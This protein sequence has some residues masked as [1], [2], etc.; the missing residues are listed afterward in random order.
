MRRERTVG[1]GAARRNATVRARAD[2]GADAA[3]AALLDCAGGVL[4]QYLELAEQYGTHFLGDYSDT[5]RGRSSL[6]GVCVV[7]LMDF[8]GDG[9]EDLFVVYSNGETERTT[10]DGYNF[11]VYNFP[12]ERTYEIEVW[13]HEDRALKRLLHESGVSFSPKYQGEWRSGYMRSLY[14]LYVTV[15][16]DSDGLPVIQL[17]TESEA[18]REYTNI[19][20]S[21]GEVVRD[22]LQLNRK[23]QQL[24]LNGA[25]IDEAEWSARVAGYD[26]ILLSALLADSSNASA[27]V[28]DWYGIDYCDTQRQTN[29]VTAYLSRKDRPSMER[30][31]AAE[32]DYM[33]L[34]M[35]ELERMNRTEGYAD[36]HLYAL[37][38]M[39][40]DGVPEMILY[41]GSSGAGTHHHFYMVID[42]ELVDCGYDRRT[43]MFVD[44]NGGVVAYYAR[45]GGYFIQKITLVG[46][47]IVFTDIA[48]GFVTVDSQDYPSLEELG[49][50]GY[51]YLVYCPPALMFGFY[52]DGIPKVA[53]DAFE[54]LLP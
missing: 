5:Y 41:E 15:F 24:T 31:D 9:A 10:V 38:D 27:E 47:E 30:F 21:D 26:K 18:G 14:R 2:G 34:Y 7:N 12:T 28:F 33:S 43:N 3:R 19:Y 11:E 37:Y 1:R 54:E 40:N 23:T 46:N 20:C 39:N 6:G 50:H 52:A 22:T 4:Q 35:R 44:G 25:A 36:D 51:D 32:S 42:G 49:Y 53:E 8:N 45:M 17:C 29:A 48:D 13:T 16:E